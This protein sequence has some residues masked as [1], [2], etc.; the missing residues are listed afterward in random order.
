MFDLTVSIVRYKQSFEELKALVDRFSGSKL[1]YWIYMVDNSP[2]PYPPELVEMF[3]DRFSYQFIGRNLGY[4]SGH[5]LVMK[6]ILDDTKYHLVI[7]PDI[8]FEKDILSKIYEYMEQQDDI[9]LLMPKVLNEDGSIQRLCKLLPSPLDLFGRRFLSDSSWTKR[10]NEKYELHN[11]DYASVL[12]TPCLSGCFMFIRISVLRKAGFFDAR[13]FM[14]LEDY[15][16]TRRVNRFS[17]TVFYPE[18]SVIHGH[19]K[20]SFKNKKLFMIHISSAVKYFNKWG[21]LFDTEKNQLNI[22]TL[23]A[24]DKVKQDH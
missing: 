13:Y 17:R 21:W 1:K 16:L 2:V 19:K 20:E 9:G 7:N 23:A 4:G 6:Q 8:I 18:V 3:G 14:Y 22:K 15:D 5:N 11:F 24:I 12:N 10:R